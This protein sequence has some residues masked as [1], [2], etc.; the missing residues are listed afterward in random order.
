MF[1][2]PLS[3]LVAY[4]AL[5][6]FSLLLM[7]AAGLLTHARAPRLGLALI[8]LATASLYALSTP[9]LSAVLL[10]SLEVASAVDLTDPP[11]ADAI[12]V[13]G[14]GERTD[15]AEYRSDSPTALSLERLRYTA[16]L[17]RATH[18]PILV[19]GGKANT[20]TDAE[21]TLMRR[22]LT[23]EFHT[24]VRWLE[25]AAYTTWDNAR[26]SAP[27]LKRA[28]V[29]RIFLVSHAWH[30]QRAVPLFEQQGLQVIPA[31][32]NFSH[33]RFETMLDILP[34]MIGL[35]DSTYAAHEWLGILWYH[36][37]QQQ[38]SAS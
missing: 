34:G 27:I 12:V 30:M 32:I 35:R 14:G 6:P 23:R 31:G 28:G 5:P 26:L 33:A 24:P 15:A 9:W 19:T 16:H 22:V 20:A 2:V 3:S 36:F 1:G 25:D 7:L 11:H 37:R 29:K 8:A 4:A 18:L 17:Y 10:Q 38:E 21:G 13:L